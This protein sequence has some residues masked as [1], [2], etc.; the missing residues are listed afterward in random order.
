[1]R[2]HRGLW[3]YYGKVILCKKGGLKLDCGLAM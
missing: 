2:A 3:M 1:M